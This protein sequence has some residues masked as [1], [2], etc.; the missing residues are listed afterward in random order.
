VATSYKYMKI[1]NLNEF[2]VSKLITFIMT[3]QLVGNKL[4]ND[5][6]L[7]KI[8]LV[9]PLIGLRRPVMLYVLHSKLSFCKFKLIPILTL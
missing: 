4:M 5:V 8:N 2:G 3:L 1:D 6:D 7:I 9:Q